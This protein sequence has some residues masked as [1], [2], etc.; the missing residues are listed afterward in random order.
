VPEF[1]GYYSSSGPELPGINLHVASKSGQEKRQKVTY[2]ANI[3]AIEQC[4]G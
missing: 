2:H 4:R 3:V 1:G